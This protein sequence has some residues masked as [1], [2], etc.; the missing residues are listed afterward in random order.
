MSEDAPTTNTPLLASAE[1]TLWR[2][3]EEIR[4]LCGERPDPDTARVFGE[5]EATC[6]RIAEALRQ[7][8]AR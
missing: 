6:A 8:E 1:A 3:Y 5:I 2:A 4:A 7:A